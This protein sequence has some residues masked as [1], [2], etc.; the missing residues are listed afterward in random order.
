MPLNSLS[1]AKADW[2]AALKGCHA[3]NM[4]WARSDFCWPVVQSSGKLECSFEGLSCQQHELRKIRLF[5]FAALQLFKRA[6]G[7]DMPCWQLGKRLWRGVSWMKWDLACWKTLLLLLLLLLVVVLVLVLLLL[8]RRMHLPG[9]T[10]AGTHLVVYMYDCTVWLHVDVQPDNAVIYLHCL[11]AWP[12]WTGPISRESALPV[13]DSPTGCRLP[14]QPE[15]KH[16]SLVLN[17]NCL[18]FC[19]GT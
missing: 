3:T 17:C 15:P 8:L 9:N 13:A 5:W 14:A 12:T 10:E 18:Y 11:A 2:N 19:T 16:L 4:N 6:E 7:Q 1:P